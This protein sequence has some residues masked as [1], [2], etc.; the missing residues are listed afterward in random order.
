M[1]NVYVEAESLG[2]QMHILVALGIKTK[3]LEGVMQDFVQFKHE[4]Q[5]HESRMILKILE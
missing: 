3:K 5:K 4:E 2:E 1:K